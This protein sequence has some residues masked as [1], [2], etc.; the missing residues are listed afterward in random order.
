MSDI[1]KIKKGTDINLK[2]KA[3]RVTESFEAPSLYALKPSNFNGIRPK[4]AVKEGDEVKAG[5][6]IYFSK[7]DERIV[8]T[9]PVSGE[10]TEVERGEKR[11]ILAIKILADKEIKYVDFKSADP[12]K[13]SREE[14]LEKLLTSGC[15]PL[16]VQRPY[17][18]VAD[19]NATPKSIFISAYNTAPL[20]ADVQYV[21]AGE[22]A[23]F[24]TGIDALAK[25]TAGKIHLS[26]PGK[27]D[28]AKA[29]TQAKGVV[30]H[31]FDGP[32]PAGNVGVQIHHI[33]PINKGDIVWTI[34]PQDVII[35]GKLFAEGKFI[36]K[37]KVALAGSEVKA[38]KYYEITIGAQLT[39][40]LKEKLTPVKPRII[41]GN[42]Y[43]GDQVAAD[44]FMSFL[45][46]EICVIPEGDEPEFLG[47]IL[48]G[49]GKWSLS[50][51]YFSWLSPK[52][53]YVINA[54]M[55]GE[56][57]AY[58]VTGEYDSVFPF[59]IYPQQLIKSIMMGDIEKMEQL[60]IYE[61]IEEDFALCEVVCTSK[62][63]VQD[64][65]RKG[66]ELAHKE[67]G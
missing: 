17:G 39:N 13:L 47:W 49:F 63:A 67:L 35:I 5:Q 66:L 36:A 25:L 16:I 50:R 14:V 41:S 64:T 38:P 12:S 10:V 54:N 15:W 6:P 55:H 2:G 28:V 32:H 45:S 53:E 51:A 27:G 37:R 33:D 29:Y 65:V 26:I 24:Q 43:T 34:A 23:A 52:K 21:V 9:S 4:L 18:I 58:V 40:L 8:F 31:K 1:I 3:Q 30:L 22:E 62:I 57:R 44:G 20:A 19:P 48:P 60:G 7:D 61:V 59:D 11:K 56:E 46:K 42:V